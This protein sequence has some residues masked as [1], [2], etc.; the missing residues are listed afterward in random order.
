MSKIISSAVIDPGVYNGHPKMTTVNA[1][2]MTA[3]DILECIN[4]LK[5]KNC[6]G[7][8]RIPQRILIDGINVL[9]G[10]LSKLFALIQ[11]KGKLVLIF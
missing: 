5:I 2:F 8:D 1:D 10:P 9:I 7:Y 6:E 11:T 4:Q 3:V